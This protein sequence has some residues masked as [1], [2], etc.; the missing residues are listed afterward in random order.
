MPNQPYNPEPPSPPP[1]Q[2]S[3]PPS[4]ESLIAGMPTP[5]PGT[6]DNLLP[7]NLLA[8]GMAIDVDIDLG[9]R[10]SPVAAPYRT[11]NQAFWR[12]H[13]GRAIKTVIAMGV[14]GGTANPPMPAISTG[15]DNDVLVAM[16]VQC[17]TPSN[18]MDGVQCRAC[19]VTLVFE[20]QL[21][22]DPTVDVFDM[23]ASPFDS[24]PAAQNVLTPADFETLLDQASQVQSFQ[25]G[26]ISF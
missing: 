22:P 14:G 25:G 7:T 9:L 3:V 10:S 26:P 17:F 19:V 1:T 16:S 23:G 18:F 4:L 8:W 12:A 24:T 11:A 15:Q 13:A 20:M 5:L 6:L 2:T 21:S